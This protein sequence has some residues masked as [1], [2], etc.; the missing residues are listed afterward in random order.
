MTCQK[1]RLFDVLL[2]AQ[3]GFLVTCQNTRSFIA[4]LP[5]E[6][7]FYSRHAKKYRFNALMSGKAG[8]S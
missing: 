7:R 1:P 8:F 2:H 4:L 5:T 6:S 3:A